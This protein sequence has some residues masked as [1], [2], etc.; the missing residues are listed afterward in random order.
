MAKSE[1]NKFGNRCESI[2]RIEN[3]LPHRKGI[4][5]KYKVTNHLVFTDNPN[6]GKM[7]EARLILNIGQRKVI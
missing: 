4:L 6:T 5:K 7:T 1:R 2:G 3:G